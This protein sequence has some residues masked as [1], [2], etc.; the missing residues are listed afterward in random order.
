MNSL[1][2]ISWICLGSVV[3]V[4]PKPTAKIEKAEN[5]EGLKCSLRLRCY[6]MIEMFVLN[7]KVDGKI[8]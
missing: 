8:K 6:Q 5:N 7:Q 3:Y 4:H 2:K 1:P